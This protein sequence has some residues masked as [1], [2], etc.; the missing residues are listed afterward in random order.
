MQRSIYLINPRETYPYYHGTDVLQAWG[1]SNRIAIADLTMPT[2][3]AMVPPDWNITLCDERLEPVDLDTPAEVI[4]ITGKSSQQMRAI[5]LAK[6][7]RRRGKIVLIGGPYA[8]LNPDEMREHADI[9]VRGE[10]EE[11]ATKLFADIEAGNWQREYEGGKPDLAK[12][13]IP[14][15]DLTKRG[16]ALLGQVQT[17]RGCPFECEFCDVIQYL[18]RKQRWKEPDQVVAELEVLYARG[19]RGIFFADDNFTV[20]RR[21]AWALAER[22]RDWNADRPA[23]RM[24][25]STQVSIDIAREPD[26]LALCHEAGFGSVFIGIETSNEASLAE[27][28]KRQNMRVD[29]AEEVRKVT[30][31][32]LLTFCGMIVGFDHDDSMIFERQ[33][34][35]ISR[36][37]SPIIQ[38][39]VL[40]AP[41][42]TPLFQ[43]LKQE[44][45]ILDDDRTRSGSLLT[46]NIAPKLMTSAE[47]HN[48]AKWLVNQVF[49]PSSFAD[50]V[51]AFADCFQARSTATRQAAV[52]VVS[53]A[54]AKKL[55]TY[56]AEERAMLG[57][58]DRVRSLRPDLANQLHWSLMYYCQARYLFETN[59]LWDPQLGRQARP[60]AA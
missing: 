15:W 37:P 35:F 17:S 19:F 24:T 25:F 56:G 8:S 4:G 26:L 20:M 33:A 31:A 52:N 60:L 16:V 51:E 22:L 32:G 23:G 27:T 29:L 46:T 43:R 21:R 59:G 2:V 9:F 3:A 40:I 47:L 10:I 34:E 50:R 11:I 53:Q 42:A 44:G 41:H 30:A 5:E 18:G 57:R 14:R 38:L 48:G 55:A 6:E 1:I 45:R 13:P 36:L 49:A 12:S 39:N 54:L 28:H 58:I 7:F